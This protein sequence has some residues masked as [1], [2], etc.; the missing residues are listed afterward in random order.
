[1]SVVKSLCH[2]I[3]KHI[4]YCPLCVRKILIIHSYTYDIKFLCPHCKDNN[5]KCRYCNLDYILKRI[6]D[7]GDEEETNEI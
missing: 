5:D 4:N 2:E 3:F 6:E 1:M 7:D